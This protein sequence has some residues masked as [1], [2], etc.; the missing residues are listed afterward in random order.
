M[1]K[2]LRRD[3]DA[4]ATLP[5]GGKVIDREAVAAL[6]ESQRILETARSE[7]AAILA[8]AE[9]AHAEAV[10]RGLAEGREQGLAEWLQKTEE[11]RAAAAAT[12]DQSRPQIVRLALRVAEKILR[13]RLADDPQA[14]VPMIDEALRAVRSQKRVLLYVHPDDVALLEEQRAAW[15]K[16][17]PTIGTIDLVADDGLDRGGCRIETEFGR[18]DTTIA[19]QLRVLERHLL[20]GAEG[21]E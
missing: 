2:I 13:Q 5:G 9:A 4:G 10:E 21:S 15:L 8:G 1:S 12:I 11:L 20:G 17:N 7:A 6:G 16:K 14:I 3:P 18:I 19:N